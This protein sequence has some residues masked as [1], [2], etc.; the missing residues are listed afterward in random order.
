M[1]NFVLIFEFLQGDAFACEYATYIELFTEK[2][3]SLSLNYLVIF[4]E[5]SVEHKIRSYLRIV[6]QDQLL[7]FCKTDFKELDK[8]SVESIDSLERMAIFTILNLPNH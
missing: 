5:K 8:N 7:N 1:S 2:I 4:I 3:I 6:C